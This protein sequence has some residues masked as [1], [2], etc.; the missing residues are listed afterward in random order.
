[1]S[2]RR[3]TALDTLIQTQRNKFVKD[4]NR[5]KR[6]VFHR[7][8][9]VRYTQDTGKMSAVIPMILIEKSFRKFPTTL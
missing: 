1:M 2:I 6:F 7:A 9:E 5:L 4:P 8:E 3:H